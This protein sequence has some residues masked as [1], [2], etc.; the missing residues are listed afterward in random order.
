MLALVFALAS[1]SMLPEDI[2]ATINGFLGIEPEP[3]E[4]VH[5]FIV[6]SSK[7]ATCTESG[8]EFSKC[9]CGEEKTTV[10]EAL[11][12][13]I[14]NKAHYD[15]T[16]EGYG[17][18]YF[19]CDRCDGEKK[20]VY[21]DPLG[22]EFG[23]SDEPSRFAFCQREKCEKANTA[24]GSSGKYL[25]TLTF[26]FTEDHEAEL[27]A[28]Y[29]EVLALIEAAPEY[30]PALHGYVEEGALA[31]EFKYVDDIHTELYE[32]ILYAI[33][34]RQIAEIDYYC[35][36]KNTELEDRYS[37]M[38]DYYTDLIAKFYSLSQPF[39]DSCYRD[40]YYYGI[41]EEE[42]K[43][44]LFDSN[45]LADP[46]YTRLKNRNDELELEFLA[47][48]S[49]EISTK[50]NEIYAEYA[51]NNN[52]MAQ[53][54]GY[55]N[56][57]E[58]AYENVYGREYSYEDVEQITG[59][60]TKH[61]TKV[62]K[63]LFEEYRTNY[64]NPL[65]GKPGEEYSCQ[66]EGSFFG[67]SMSNNYVNNYIDMMNFTSNPDK[68]ISFS[69]ELN[70]LC[71][72]GNL[73]IGEYSGAF[74]TYLETFDAPIAYFSEGYDTP[75]TIVHEFGHYMN[76]IYNRSEYEQSYDILEMHSQGNEMLYLASLKGQISDGAYEYI[77][78][79][80]MVNM[81]ATVM[82]GLAVDA[83]ERAIYTDSYDG[84][85]S[86]EIMADGTITYNEYDKLY[87]GINADL[88]LS[89]ILSSN[90]WKYGMT[91]TSPCYYVSYSVSAL[92]VLQ[93]YTKA[94]T[95]GFDAAADSYLKLVTYTDVNPDFTD[96]EILEYAGLYT[97]ED[98]RLYSS[99]AKFFQDN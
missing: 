10:L 46:E 80:H 57:L 37:Y 26:N 44:Y 24:F 35:D 90:Y 85:Y 43:A 92:S 71:T 74:V 31:E 39:Y 50:V 83:F 9:A 77:E 69:D 33:A 63:S 48:N 62:L 42:I 30:D 82:S 5:E 49:P 95:E 7:P 17:Y 96:S 34:Q 11:G 20:T 97:V 91:I 2:Q 65:S 76:E 58:Y 84:T 52:K 51:A 98:E 61:I 14:V 6:E 13:N 22:H 29:E 99:F 55:E 47:I 72:D 41:T 94:Q 19:I 67:N 70:A 21:I 12:H 88:G 81:L 40:F 27:D 68:Q 32:L 4:H 28:K 23:T 93:I 75:F 86:D 60:V 54:M 1:C 8:E 66:F 25:E 38:M 18:D 59:F 56:Y 79:D 73:Y 15:P 45:T 53:L 3:P 16:C 78:T 36:M 87:E 89:E 64:F